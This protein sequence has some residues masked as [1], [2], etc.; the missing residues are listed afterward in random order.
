VPMKK[1]RLNLNLMTDADIF[2]AIHDTKK[3]F[4]DLFADIANGLESEKL[5]TLYPDHRGV[6]ISM[7]NELKKCPYQVLDIFRNFDKKEGHNIRILNWWGHG[8]YIFVFFGKEKAIETLS[9][10]NFFPE[11]NYQLAKGS[12]PWDYELIL[13]ASADYMDHR[14]ENIQLHLSKFGYLQ[15]FKSIGLEADID[16]LS[17]K[18]NE[19]L[20][21]IFHFHRI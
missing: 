17:I 11:N 9:L 10:Q 6:K 8:L 1:S 12:S 2:S 20:D 4:K 13:S 18:I 19:E 21:Q 5:T 16:Q 14:E 7:G 3:Q 15:W